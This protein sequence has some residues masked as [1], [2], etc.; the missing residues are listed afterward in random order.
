MF[1]NDIRLN[2]VWQWQLIFRLFSSHLTAEL[3]HTTN[4]GLENIW[5]HLVCCDRC[6]YIQFSHSVPPNLW[7]TTREKSKW[8]SIYILHY[9]AVA[10]SFVDKL[11]DVKKYA[12]TLP[13]IR[14][15]HFIR[16]LTWGVF[17][18]QSVCLCVYL[19][20]I[21]NVFHSEVI[22][23]LLVCMYHK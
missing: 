8:V 11:L 6:T 5:L 13:L 4:N 7:R 17:W 23:C 18:Q 22:V 1:A 19:C 15:F 14:C 3:A 9:S 2:S 12:S 10:N 21:I 20:S 16:H